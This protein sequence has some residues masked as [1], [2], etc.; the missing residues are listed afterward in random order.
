[1]GETAALAL[2]LAIT[3]MTHAA[4]LTQLVQ[5]ANAQGRDVSPAELD[6]LRAKAT[7]A[8]D[9]LEAAIAQRAAVPKP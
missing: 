8:V 1:M 9:G 3:A 6:A 2:E 5:A 7:A 4:E